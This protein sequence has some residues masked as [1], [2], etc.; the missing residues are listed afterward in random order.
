MSAVGPDKRFKAVYVTNKTKDMTLEKDFCS[1]V[2]LVNIVRRFYEK[3]IPR[4]L[5]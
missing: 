2:Y 1:V 4:K 5:Y 3:Q